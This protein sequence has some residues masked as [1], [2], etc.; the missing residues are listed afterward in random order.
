MGP[1]DA[2][3]NGLNVRRPIPWYRMGYRGFEVYPLLHHSIPVIHL[4]VFLT[5]HM[6][7]CV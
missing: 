3:T 5:N 7:V 1:I 4:S 2:K 6:F